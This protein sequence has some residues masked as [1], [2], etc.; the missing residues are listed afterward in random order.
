MPQPF[1][2]SVLT[3]LFH[4]VRPMIRRCILSL[5]QVVIPH[6]LSR[7]DPDLPAYF[8]EAVSRKLEEVADVHGV[9]LHCGEK[10]LLPFG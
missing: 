3:V 1:S 10:R 4:Q 2:I 5:F 9:S 6:S 8:D 7:L